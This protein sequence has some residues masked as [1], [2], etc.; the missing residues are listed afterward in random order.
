[1]RGG[2]GGGGVG[3][4]PFIGLEGVGEGRAWSLGAWGRAW[5]RDAQWQGA[6]RRARVRGATLLLPRARLSGERFVIK[7]QTPRNNFKRVPF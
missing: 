6:T 1:M 3:G 7:K 2:P 4:S 5:S